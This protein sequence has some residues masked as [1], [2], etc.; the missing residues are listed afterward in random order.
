[1]IYIKLFE[2]FNNV[3]FDVESRCNYEDMNF[4]H[5]YFSCRID[6]VIVSSCIITYP[7][8]STEYMKDDKK[9]VFQIVAG[10]REFFDEKNDKFV[11]LFYVNSIEEG[12]GYGR[13]LFENLNKYLKSKNIRRIYINVRKENKGAH[14]FYK[15]IGFKKKYDG[16]FN[17][18][19][20]LY[21]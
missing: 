16:V 9:K 17:I 18:A 21:I 5:E 1:M 6:G 12:K 8:L 10:G 3:T 4:P 13:L 20:I 19:Y 14:D 2:D 7:T 15:K 11:K